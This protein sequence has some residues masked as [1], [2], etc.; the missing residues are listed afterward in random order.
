MSTSSWSPKNRSLC[1]GAER[2]LP[3]DFFRESPKQA[4]IHSM[5]TPSSLKKRRCESRVYNKV[6][7]V[8]GMSEY[9]QDTQA[10]KVLKQ[11]WADSMIQCSLHMNDIMCINWKLNFVTK[12]SMFMIHASLSQITQIV[13]LAFTFGH[14][15]HFEPSSIP[16]HILCKWFSWYL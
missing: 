3:W 2:P 13:N 8:A 11:S 7:T 16:G 1:F 5:S 15:G 10:G 14:I 4:S 12:P 6:Y 9:Q